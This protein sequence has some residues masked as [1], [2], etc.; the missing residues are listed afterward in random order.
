MTDIIASIPNPAFISLYFL[1]YLICLLGGKLLTKFDSS[2]AWRMPEPTR[3]PPLAI[4]AFSR[5][6][7][8][9]V[10]TAIFSMMDK[11]V[12]YI[13]GSGPLARI[14]QIEGME[15][16]LEDPVEIK[17]YEFLSTSCSPG[18]I[19]SDKEF[20]KEIDLSLSPYYREFEELRLIRNSGDH[21]WIWA[22]TVMTTGIA[23]LSGGYKLSLGISNSKPVGALIITILLAV[24]SLFLFMKPKQHGKTRL[25][26]AYLKK[27]KEHF[28][29]LKESCIIGDLPEGVDPALPLA[30]YG[31]GIIAGIEPYILF[32]NAFAP[33]ASALFN[34]NSMPAGCN[35]GVDPQYNK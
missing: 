10:R 6:T 25:G 26:F 9:A 18:D 14:K 21:F 3:F 31:P 1:L 35:T 19:L 11:K 20:L 29:W 13:T 12:L 2:M 15:K 16:K 8:E 32:S 30:L 34:A 27:L 7:I 24:T 33:P 23:G 22:I 28:N 4:A 5:G 17:I